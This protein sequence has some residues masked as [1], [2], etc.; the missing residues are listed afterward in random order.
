MDNDRRSASDLH[1]LPFAR[2][3][4]PVLQRTIEHQFRAVPL[5]DDLLERRPGAGTADDHF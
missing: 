1:R 5:G 4:D 3:H 2:L